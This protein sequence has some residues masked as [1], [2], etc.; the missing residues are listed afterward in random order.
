[1]NLL[2]LQIGLVILAKVLCLVLLI[3]RLPP[4]NK[5]GTSLK[6]IQQCKIRFRTKPT[7]SESEVFVQTE[8]LFWKYETTQAFLSF[9]VVCF[10]RESPVDMVWGQHQNS[11]IVFPA[12]KDARL[13]HC[14]LAA[15]RNLT[16]LRHGA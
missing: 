9:T 16:V 5:Q 2:P 7:Q 15:A 14:Q 3:G 1:M 10:E 11:A 6:W 12:A 4:E 13:S 8:T